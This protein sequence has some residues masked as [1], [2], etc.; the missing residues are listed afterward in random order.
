[1]NFF[2]LFLVVLMAFLS[3]S[4]GAE[5]RHMGRAKSLSRNNKIE[6]KT[7]TTYPTDPTFGVTETYAD[8]YC[9]SPA[10]GTMVLLDTCYVGSSSSSK[11]TC[12]KYYQ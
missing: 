7:V 6:L 10:S 12:S 1:M 3:N 5:L 8:T 2:A 4:F 11:Y 9:T